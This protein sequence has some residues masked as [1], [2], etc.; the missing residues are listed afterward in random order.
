M[1][2]LQGRQDSQL[3]IKHR[4]LSLRLAN[5]KIAEGDASDNAIIIVALLAGYEVSS[6]DSRSDW[7]G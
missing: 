3:V 6:P 2:I 1:A 4:G 5:K 7:F